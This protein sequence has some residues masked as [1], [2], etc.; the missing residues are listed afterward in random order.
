MGRRRRES[1]HT[2]QKNNTIEDLVGN[3]ENGYPVPDSHKKMINVSIEHHDTHKTIP[4]I[5]NH[6]R[7][8]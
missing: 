3:E 8:H 6:G 4:Q 2:P 7:G 1:N 5:G